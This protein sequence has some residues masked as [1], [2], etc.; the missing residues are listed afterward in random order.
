LDIHFNHIDDDLLVKY[1][2]G[3]S[4][5]HENKVVEDWL[6]E[7]PLNAEYLGQFRK[8]IEEST[9]PQFHSTMNENLAWER[10]YNKIPG[11]QV[12]TVKVR[13]FLMSPFLRIAS[14][15][16]FVAALGIIAYQSLTKD[17]PNEQIIVQ[18]GQ[19]VIRDTLSDGSVV[20]LNKNST[21]HFP[22]KFTGNSRPVDLDG[23]AFFNV[24]PDK[25]KPFLIHVNNLTVKVVGT[26]FN[27]KSVNGKTE[28]VVETGIVEVTR[29]NK[30]VALKPGERVEVKN[31]DTV[32]QKKPVEDSLYNYYRSNEFVCDNTPLW[33][34][35]EVLNEAYHVHIVVAKQKRNLRLTTTF[36]NESLD[37]ILEIVTMTFNLD[38]NRTSDEIIIQ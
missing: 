9:K 37:R 38:I 28:V 15:F 27:V 36:S 32:L 25:Q 4:S 19:K 14:I 10:F 11:K 23:E 2:L 13:S 3:E 16:I 31:T 33:K 8:I 20:T 34:L 22:K 29:N 7:D 30:T 35:A 26:S 12:E 17:Q 6:S 1:L 5:P 21:I 24:T 18:A